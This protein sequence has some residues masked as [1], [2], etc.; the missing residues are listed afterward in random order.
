MKTIRIPGLRDSVYPVA[1]PRALVPDAPAP[2]QLLGHKLLITRTQT[3]LLGSW[4]RPTASP[5]PQQ[6]PPTPLILLTSYP[7]LKFASRLHSHTQ[8]CSS[9]GTRTLG[10]L[11]LLASPLPAPVTCSP[12]SS[13]WHTRTHTER[14]VRWHQKQE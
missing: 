3:G 11:W 8:S 5:A 14:H 2:L 4:S 1:G 6:L 7:G 9:P 10:S 13:C 12:F